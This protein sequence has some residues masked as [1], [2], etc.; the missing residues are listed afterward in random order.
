VLIAWRDGSFTSVASII[1]K[2]QSQFNSRMSLV[3]LG[4][5]QECMGLI[6]TVSSFL[7]CRNYGRSE[8]FV[9]DHGYYAAILI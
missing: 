3:L 6:R 1:K 9:L 5:S 4:G 7:F 8:M 2:F